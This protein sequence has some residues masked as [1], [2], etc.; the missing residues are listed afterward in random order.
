MMSGQKDMARL[1]E[2]VAASGYAGQKVVILSG[3]RP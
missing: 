2:A 3:G 1:R